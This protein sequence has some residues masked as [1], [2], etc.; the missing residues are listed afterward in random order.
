MAEY[1]EIEAGEHIQIRKVRKI[2]IMG[3][4]DRLKINKRSETGIV[5]ESWDD[6]Q[7]SEI[8]L[9]TKRSSCLRGINKKGTGSR[10][11]KSLVKVFKE[12]KDIDDTGTE[13]SESYLNGQR[14]YKDRVETPKFQKA[15]NSE[16]KEL[17]DLYD[18]LKFDQKLL[19]EEV[20]L[21][22]NML[23]QFKFDVVPSRA[24]SFMKY[25]LGTRRNSPLS[26]K[27][28]GEV[29]VCKLQTSFKS[30]RFNS[31]LKNSPKVSQ[32]LGKLP[33]LFGPNSEKKINRNSPSKYNRDKPVISQHFKLLKDVFTVKN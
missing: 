19:R 33:F 28:L 9:K 29:D 24:S 27:G 18:K 20:N 10:T 14:I 6:Q 31:S 22:R 21:Q 12:P 4:D 13:Q 15:E 8:D 25:G 26:D 7:D 23:K 1:S 16:F 2:K 17:K 30:V 11:L 32:D 3:F 5:E